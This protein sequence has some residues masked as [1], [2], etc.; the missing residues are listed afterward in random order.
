ME[1][2]GAGKILIYAKYEHKLW[3]A[4][5]EFTKILA[6]MKLDGSYANS[7]LLFSK[8]QECISDNVPIEIKVE[9]YMY[10]FRCLRTALPMMDYKVHVFAL[11]DTRFRYVATGWTKTI[12]SMIDNGLMH[13]G[14]SREN[15]GRQRIVSKFLDIVPRGVSDEMKKSKNDDSLNFS[16]W[17]IKFWKL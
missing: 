13:L 2:R 11:W 8:T 9:I 5:K 16:L 1:K 10:G 14:L 6:K 12:E 4:V 3:E 15:K 7:S 17:T